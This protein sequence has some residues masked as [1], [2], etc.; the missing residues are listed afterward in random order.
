MGRRT[1]LAAGN[2]RAGGTLRQAEA[3][4]PASWSRALRPSGV[5]ASPRSVEV[6][7]EVSGIE[8]QQRGRPLVQR[9]LELSAISPLL[10]EEV[11]EVV[12][13]NAHAPIGLPLV[14]PP[15]YA[16]TGRCRSPAYG[17]RPRRSG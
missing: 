3:P 1:S 15:A 11:T 17:Q 9:R 2:K 13:E 8:H 6:P 5:G 4:R 7:L 10:R 14:L 16:A 12:A